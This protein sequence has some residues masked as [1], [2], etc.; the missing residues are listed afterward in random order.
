MDLTFSK[1]NEERQVV[2]IQN[3]QCDG[4]N[5]G[6]ITKTPV[7]NVHWDCPP[8]NHVQKYSVSTH[9]QQQRIVK[10]TM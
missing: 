8:S 9:L 7:M 3:V 2:A 1:E 4:N 5:L 10:T 6:F